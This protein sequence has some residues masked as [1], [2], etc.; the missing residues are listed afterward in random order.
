MVRPRIALFPEEVVALGPHTTFFIL[1][2]AR[3][4]IRL[5]VAQLSVPTLHDYVRTKVPTFLLWSYRPNDPEKTAEDRS[6]RV[7][8]S[9]H[10]FRG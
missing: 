2:G 6:T 10:G 1:P 4:S 8:L 9:V 7:K 3:L 5:K